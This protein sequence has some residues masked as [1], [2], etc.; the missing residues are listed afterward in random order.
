VLSAVAHP[1]L[2]LLARGGH[3]LVLDVGRSLTA[4]TTLIRGCEPGSVFRGGVV[5]WTVLALLFVGGAIGAE[6]GIRQYGLGPRMSW[7]FRR[8]RDA[9]LIFAGLLFAF[10]VLLSLTHFVCG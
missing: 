2:V 4:G 6:V 3:G 7:W 5:E 9:L 1:H 10:G 8:V